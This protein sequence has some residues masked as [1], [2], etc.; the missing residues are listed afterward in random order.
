M[1]PSMKHLEYLVALDEHRHFR[2]AAD[3]SFITQPAL[4]TQIKQI[5]N[6]LG[7]SLFE[8][9]RRRVLPTRAGEEVVSRA[10]RILA[11]VD[12]L[13][14]SAQSLA[15][16]LSGPLRLGIIPTVAPYLLPRILPRLRQ[17]YGDLRLYLR[18]EQTARCLSLLQEGVLDVVVL[19]LP[20]DGPDLNTLELFQDRFWLAVPAKHPLANRK[21][22]RE[23]DLQDEEILL[24]ED[25]HCLRDQALEVCKLAGA[26]ERADFRATSLNT[27]TQMVSSGL[28]VTLLPEMSLE[29]ETRRARGITVHPFTRP[30]PARTVGLAWRRSSPREADFKLLGKEIQAASR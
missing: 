12:D 15:R 17:K 13:V 19:A 21:R 8:R 25:G 11:E 16:P 28:G 20:V 2:K 27:L 3:A 14:E 6:L 29:T 24:L 18:E 4:S 1:R 10:R 7:V 30:S 9:D 22:L 26:R 23:K 5:E